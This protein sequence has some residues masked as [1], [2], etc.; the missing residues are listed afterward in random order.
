MKLRNPEEAIE[1]LFEEDVIARVRGLV[2]ALCVAL[3]IVT[4]GYGIY[5]RVVGGKNESTR[6]S[7][8]EGNEGA[9]YNG[10]AI[11]A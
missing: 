9:E 5:L 6:S 3:G 11:I 1:S 8:G 10:N 7:S 2:I 4:T